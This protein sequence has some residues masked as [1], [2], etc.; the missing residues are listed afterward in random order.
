MPRDCACHAS[1]YATCDHPGG[2][3]TPGGCCATPRPARAG[4]CI[5]CPVIRPG[6]DPRQPHQPPVCD[7]DRTL[8]D[9]WLGDIGRLH[10]ILTEPEPPIVDQRRHN[11]YATAYLPGG[12]RHTWNKGSYPSDPLAALGGVAPINS[13]SKA[14]AVT[15]S[16]ERP[17]P[18]RADLHDITAPLRGTNLTTAGRQHPDDH[19]GHL[20]ATTVLDGWVRSWRDTLWPGHHLPDGTVT[21]LVKWLRARL[22]DACDRY[23][24]IDEFAGEIRALHNTLRAMAGETDPQPERCEGVACKRCDM[25]ML[26]RRADGSGDVDCLNPA[27]AAVYR[28]DEY[29]DWTK[30]LAAEPRT[31]AA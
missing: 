18:I 30:T 23:P 29:A 4:D 24:I 9:R 17:I 10:S 27:C 6:T 26:F 31:H 1:S 25:Q 16:R 5:T 7:G 13:R 14:P 15:G 11:R 19:I 2:C 20:P 8:I 28:E 22:T 3:G 21:E 12:T